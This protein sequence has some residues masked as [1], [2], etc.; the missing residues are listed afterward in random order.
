MNTSH[1]T[2]AQEQPAALSSPEAHDQGAEHGH[3]VD[4]VELVRIVL[5]AIAVVV[6][7]L[8]PWRPFLNVNFVA[9]AATLAGGYPI[10]RE[11]F[12]ALKEQ[13]RPRTSR[14]PSVLV[15]SNARGRRQL[16]RGTT[17]PSDD[18]PGRV[19]DRAH[20]AIGRASR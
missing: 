12:E 15:A 7:W 13:A 2:Y 4:R 6:A 17:A 14:S 20:A 18:A 11:A 16:L 19:D 9:L 3:G 5:V 10:F 8:L 1:S